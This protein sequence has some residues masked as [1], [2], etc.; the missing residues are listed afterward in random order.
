MRSMSAARRPNRRGSG[1]T[2]IITA[3]WSRSRHRGQ[4]WNG[5]VAAVL[6]TLKWQVGQVRCDKTGLP[7]GREGSQSNDD[8]HERKRFL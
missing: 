6:A 5:D 2:T 7:G 1:A 3:A 8:R 4:F